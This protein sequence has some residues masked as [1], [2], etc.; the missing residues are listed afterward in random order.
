MQSNN[1]P[2]STDENRAETNSS[3]GRRGFLKKVAATGIL[4]MAGTAVGTG[5]ASATETPKS[6]E[7]SERSDSFASGNAVT[8]GYVDNTGVSPTTHLNLRAQPGIGGEVVTT[9]PPHATGVILTDDTVEMDGYTW[10]IAAW[11]GTYYVGW[12]AIEY[13]FPI[14]YTPKRVSLGAVVTSANLNTRTQP[15][16]DGE[17][18]TTVTSGSVGV[19]YSYDLVIDGYTW[20]PVWWDDNGNYAGWCA[21]EYFKPLQE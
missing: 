3:Q 9:L 15:G 5:A 19:A 6:A 14:S 7:R 2:Q 12:C 11:D 10:Q 21:S 4:G 13:L 1:S 16:L 17:V 18:V 8:A 20:K